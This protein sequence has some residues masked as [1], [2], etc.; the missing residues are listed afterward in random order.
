MNPLIGITTY[1]CDSDKGFRLPRE[2]ADAVRRAG[3]IPVLCAPGESHVD[4]LLDRVDGVVLAGGG[5]IDPVHY[6]GRAHETIYGTDPERDAS[7]LKL[8]CGLVERRMPTLA[9]C[10]GMQLVNVALGGSLVEHIP[11]EFGETIVHRVPPRNPAEHLVRLEP[12]SKLAMSLGI[13][14]FPVVSW[15][16]QA[17]RRPAACLVVVGS[18]EDQVIEAA[19]MPD[20]PWLICVQWHPELSAQRDQVQQRLFDQFVNAARQI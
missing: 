7:E 15:H 9:I 6:A 17:V 18:A 10:R 16:H 13:R 19:E 14:E 11:D 3:G 2:Y 20:H 12:S 1:G 5:D 4:G 8:V